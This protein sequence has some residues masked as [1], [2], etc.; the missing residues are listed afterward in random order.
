ML[1]WAEF[2]PTLRNST[3]ATATK[4]RDSYV[5]HDDSG[6]DLWALIKTRVQEL[7]IHRRFDWLPGEE[8]LGAPRGRE[9][10]KVDYL[11]R[12][13]LCPRRV[14]LPCRSFLASLSRSG[15]REMCF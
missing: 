7:P 14:A 9:D 10:K 13:F 11:I 8:N 3:Q 1:G 12:R 5:G 6:D 4:W 2:E 15:V